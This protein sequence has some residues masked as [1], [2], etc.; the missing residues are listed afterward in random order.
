MID[1]TGITV[2]NLSHSRHFYDAVLAALGYAVRCDRGTTVSY[3]KPIP[4]PFDDPAGEF[5]LSEGAPL[6][7][8]AHIAFR[9]RSAQ[10]VE[11]FHS[12]AL[13]LGGT[14]NGA[15]G[16]RPDYHPRYFA[17]FVFDPDGYN[18]EAVCH[19]GR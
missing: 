3:G 17:A 10:C 16:L 11:A 1:H 2:S 5:W 4:S 19:S 9:A 6:V 14:S 15:P 13:A 18:I 8:R 7:P 12:A